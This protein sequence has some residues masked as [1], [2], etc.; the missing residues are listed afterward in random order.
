MCGIVGIYNHDEASTL[1]YL[2]LFALQHRGQEGVGIVTYDDKKTFI[3]KDNGLVSDVFSDRKSLESL[4]GKI[5]LGHVRYS[6]HGGSKK[7]NIQPLV[8]NYRG[9]QI[10]LSHNGNLVNLDKIQEELEKK[11]AIFQTTSDTEFIIHLFSHASGSIEER[12]LSAFRKV[13][14]AYSMIILYGE[15]MIVARDRHGIRPLCVGKLDDATVYASETCALDLI[16][17]KYERDINPGEMVVID[18]FGEKSY[19]IAES[20]PR[21]CIFEYVYFS[22][23]DSR[24]FGEYVDKTRRKLGK[25]L[26]LEKPVEDADIVISVPDSSNTTAI[27]YSQRSSARFDIGLIRNH[28]IGRTFI[29]PTQSMRDFTTKIKFNPIGGVLKG[30]NVVVVDDSIVRGTTLKK[31]VTLIREACPKSI[32]IRIG[33][34]PV[35]FPCFYGMDFPSQN[36]LIANQKS[37]EDIRDYLEVESLEF[38]SVDGLL[39]SM[40][41]PRDHFCTACFTGKYIEP[42]IHPKIEGKLSC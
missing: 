38:I 28:Y 30:K 21:H 15:K 6:T 5:A 7:E 36:E 40:S 34:P 20:S 31:L 14:G 39:D 41:L 25:I 13:E 17:A 22:R 9:K 16:G 32:H 42:D 3:R 11:G 33:S 27:G 19:Q 8:F 37:I 10:A 12:F 24:I 18:K 23:P 4:P 2:C 1:A 35:R 26:A 29:H